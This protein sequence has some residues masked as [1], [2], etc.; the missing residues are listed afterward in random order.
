[1]D[2]FILE[3]KSQIERTSVCILYGSVILWP[4]NRDAGVCVCVGG[5]D[6]P[7]CLFTAALGDFAKYLIHLILSEAMDRT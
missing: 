7:I 3:L 2:I 4:G 1:M 5:W 6:T